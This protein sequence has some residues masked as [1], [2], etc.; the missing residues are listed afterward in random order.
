MAGL[1]NMFGG[2]FGGNKGSETTAVATSAPATPAATATVEKSEWQQVT[3]PAT[4]KPYYWNP[5]TG[6]TSWELPK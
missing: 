3:D 1:K 4:N 5:K 2:L 6:E